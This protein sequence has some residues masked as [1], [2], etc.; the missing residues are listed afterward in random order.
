MSVKVQQFLIDGTGY[1]PWRSWRWV[2][3]LFNR[4]YALGILSGT[5]T[6]VNATGVQHYAYLRGRRSYI[7]GLQREWWS[8]LL[9]RSALRRPHIPA[10]QERYGVWCGRCFPCPDCGETRWHHDCNGGAR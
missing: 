9:G 7:L 8:C 4:G 1:R 3:R 10:R 2:G 6:A 5:S